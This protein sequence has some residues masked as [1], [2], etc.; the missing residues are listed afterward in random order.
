MSPLRRQA[1]QRHDCLRQVERLVRQR[2][3]TACQT[4]QQHEVPVVHVTRCL[5]LPDRTVRHWRNRNCDSQ[6]TCSIRRGRLPRPASWDQRNQVF[7]FL[8]QRG[9]V[10]PLAALRV[11]FP[12]VPR[13]DLKEILSRY[14]QLQ[15]RIRQ[16]HQSRL[17]W[18]RP[19]TVWAADFKERREPIEGCYSWILAVK[20]L[21]SRCQLAWLPVEEATARTVQ[22][23]YVRLFEEHGRPLVLK[24]D[25]GGP[26][27]DEGTKQLLAEYDVIGLFN[28]RRRPAYNGGVERANGQL[29][30]YQEA[31]AANHG[32]AGLPTYADAEEARQLANELSR[33]EGWKGPS[34]AQL[35]EQ[36]PS[37]TSAERASFLATVT[38]QR[39]IARAALHLPPET[40]LGHY[41]AAAVDRRAV[42][43]ALVAKGLLK[44]EPRRR[45]QRA[46][47]PDEKSN[48]IAPFA[49]GAGILPT[50][51]GRAMPTVG[52]HDG[53]EE[54]SAPLEDH[55]PERVHSSTINTPASGQN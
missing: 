3:V 21:A 40:P 5:A 11:A 28:P 47:S 43:E 24:S 9:P 39:T 53:P 7:R 55:S 50:A 33:P 30:G 15:K 36:R 41:P 37:I 29:A 6:V 26:F 51:A 10:T 34:A 18:R 45:P 49:S 23:I 48:L 31:V 14:R 2:V 12:E 42:R 25:N 54:Q 19:G 27:R 16:R 44:I 8:R 46:S 4:A 13:C 17:H 38:E 35:W 22:A 1:Q 20:D 52:Q 32:Q